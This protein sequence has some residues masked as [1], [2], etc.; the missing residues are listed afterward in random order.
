MDDLS[1]YLLADVVV[2]GDSLADLDRELIYGRHASQADGS[3][4]TGAGY[5]YIPYIAH[6]SVYFKTLNI[7]VECDQR[8]TISYL[9]NDVVDKMVLDKKSRKYRISLNRHEQ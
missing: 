7:F 8:F 3:Y 1:N 4:S 9:F 2:I 6:V 5:I